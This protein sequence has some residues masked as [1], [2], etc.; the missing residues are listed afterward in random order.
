V[1]AAFAPETLLDDARRLARLAL[2]EDGPSDITTDITGVAGDREGVIR[3][4]DDIVVAGV[5]YGTELVAQAGGAVTWAIGDG[6]DAT[7]R[8]TIG[9]VRGEVS[10]VLRAER[11]LLNLLQRACGIATATRRYVDAVAGTTCRILH[12]RKTVPGLR[13]FDA[14][15]VIAGGGHLHRLGLDRVVMLKDNHWALL[16]ETG[17]G[18]PDL[19]RDA[20]QRGALGVQIE[21]ES[22]E[23]VELACRAGADR[24]LIDNRSP[25]EFG[26]LAALAR[27]HAPA[28]EI[29]ATGGI[30]LDIV[31]AYAD[32]GADFV[33]V[34]ALTHSVRAADLTLE[35]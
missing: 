23:Q 8:D 9:R 14:A 30:T 18:L 11:P 12:T 27:T 29:E 33:S 3:T 21:V 5:V 17:R 2:D 6:A 1:A 32:G 16:N 34:G 20:R 24:L 31:G 26:S 35:L 4:S 28:I 25:A 13:L 7:T 10:A 19:V 15:A 22:A